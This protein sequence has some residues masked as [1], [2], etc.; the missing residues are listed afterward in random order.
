[1]ESTVTSGAATENIKDIYRKY[2]HIILI[3]IINTMYNYAEYHILLILVTKFALKY[4]A[5]GCDVSH[6][7]SPAIVCLN[8]C[9]S[10]Y[11]SI[12]FHFQIF[13]L[14]NLTKLGAS[15]CNITLCFQPV[16]YNCTTHDYLHIF[17]QIIYTMVFG[18]GA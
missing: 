8:I 1:M 9:S 18:T 3:H 16:Q 6:H 2:K 17:K 14:C 5:Q 10:L 15:G 11:E 12:K 7:V 4:F 13:N